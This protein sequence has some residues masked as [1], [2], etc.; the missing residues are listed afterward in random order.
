MN[1]QNAKRVKNKGNYRRRQ[2]GTSIYFLLWAAF[3]VLAF[4][5]VLL[6]SFVIRMVTVQTYKN[7]AARELSEKGRSIEVAVLSEPP[8]VFGG[9]RSEYLRYLSTSFDVNIFILDESGEVLFPRMPDSGEKELNFSDKV[10]TLKAELEESETPS[11]I[12]EGKRE[13]VYG[14]KVSLYGADVDAYLYVAKS[15]RFVEAATAQVAVRTTFLAVF[16]FVLAFAVSSAVSGW[17]TKPISEMTKKAKLLANGDFNVDFHGADY[18]QEMVQLAD[19]LNFARDE[20]SKTDRMQKELI[21]NVSHDFKTPLTMIKGYASM[22]MEISGDVPEKRNKHAQVIIDE[23]DRLASLV[24]DVLDLSKLRSGLQE[25]K[26]SLVDMSA[27]TREIV[28]RFAYL[29]E[30]QGYTIVEEIEDGLFAQVDELKIGQ[31]LYNLVGNAVNYTGEDKKVFVALKKLDDKTF[32]FSVRDTGAG[33]KKEEIAT[34]WERYYR[35]SEMHKRPVKGTGLGLSI[36]KAVLERH[37]LRF[38]VE[39]EMGKGSVFYIDFT[40]VEN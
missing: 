9:N 15:L 36:V 6:F 10:Q 25:L 12:Y 38:G 16:V 17:L 32:R 40:S 37:N 21:A 19:T 30:T 5:I 7:E 2:R 13:Y 24:A 1:G 23:S 27:Y 35:S 4:V 34:I 33:I 8:E 20:L 22:I 31:A 14:A 39:S 26:T 28:E 11:V 29:R 18:G 3:S